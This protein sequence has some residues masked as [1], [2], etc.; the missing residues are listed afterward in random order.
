M[1]INIFKKQLNYKL[2]K[3]FCG[4]VSINSN[5]VS[6]RLGLSNFKEFKIIM[7]KQTHK[8][9]TLYKNKIYETSSI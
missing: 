9:C 6:A 4:E 3:I 5:E 1:G 7:Y 2:E 8:I